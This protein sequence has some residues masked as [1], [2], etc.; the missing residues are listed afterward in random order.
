MLIYKILRAD[1]WAALRAQ[2]ETAGAPIDVADGYVHFSTADQ[3]RGT[4]AKHFAGEE[5]LVLLAL[6]ADTLGE[7]LKWE[8]SRGDALFPHLYAPLRLSDVQ[9]HKPLPLG[10]DGHVFPAEMH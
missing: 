9:W 2:G 10:P 4:A 6:E 1:E 8:V 7:A 5:G 3:A